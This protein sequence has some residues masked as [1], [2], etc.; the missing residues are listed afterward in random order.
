MNIKK[1]SL[2]ILL[3]FSFIN[4]FAQDKQKGFNLTLESGGYIGSRKF[5]MLGISAISV[6][7]GH[8]FNEH[9]FIGSGGTINVYKVGDKWTPSFPLFARGRYSVLKSKI[10]PYISS[11]FG[12]DPFYGGISYDMR[13]DYVPK[14]GD[15]WVTGWKGGFYF[16]PQIGVLCRLYGRKSINL[17]VGYM[18]Q[19]GGDFSIYETNEKG[20]LKENTYNTLRAVTIKIG[21]TF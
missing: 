9:F 15:I 13:S 20:E 7:A 5:N 21:Y 3:V 16:H 19:R 4:V 6:V 12:F 2:T 18:K 17:G 11:D 1:L 14:E 10:T 8:S